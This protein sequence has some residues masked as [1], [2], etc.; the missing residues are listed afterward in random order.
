[1]FFV[2]L[3]DQVKTKLNNFFDLNVREKTLKCDSN[4]AIS[5]V[6]TLNSFHFPFNFNALE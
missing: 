1:M 2:G 6:I 4:P 3:L 5:I